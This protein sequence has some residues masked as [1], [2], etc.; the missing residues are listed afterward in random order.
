M[1]PRWSPCAPGP[2]SPPTPPSP[3]ASTVSTAP[4]SP[5]TSGTVNPDRERHTSRPTAGDTPIT[6]SRGF[7]PGKAGPTDAE[8]RALAQQIRAGDAPEGTLA[9]LKENVAAKLRVASPGYLERY[10]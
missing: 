4:W 2:S 3:P 10:S 8:L 5:S 6:T 7:C 1:T 9:L